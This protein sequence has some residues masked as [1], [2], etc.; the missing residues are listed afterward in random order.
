MTVAMATNASNVISNVISFLTLPI[1]FVQ[2]VT[3]IQV[4]SKS[5]YNISEIILDSPSF[6]EL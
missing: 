5:M 1:V 4:T 6:L 3:L 2:L